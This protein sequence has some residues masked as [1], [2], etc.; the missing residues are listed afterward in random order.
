MRAKVESRVE[1]AVDWMS[2]PLEMGVS[3]CE[4]KKQTKLMKMN[5]FHGSDRFRFLFVSIR[6]ITL[7]LFLANTED[8]LFTLDV[9]DSLTCSEAAAS[10][11]LTFGSKTFRLARTQY[12]RKLNVSLRAIQISKWVGISIF[13]HQF[14][15]KRGRKG[16]QKK[17]SLK[18]FSL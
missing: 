7:C 15:W 8:F 10:F 9:G 12:S 17:V 2:F 3:S 4:S 14:E 1:L 11:L 18:R 6:T 13:S 16:E 5:F